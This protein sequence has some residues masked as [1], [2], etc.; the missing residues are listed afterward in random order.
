MIEVVPVPE[1][2]ASGVRLEGMVIPQVTGVLRRSRSGPAPRG[3]ACSHRTGTDRGGVRVAVASTAAKRPGRESTAP[4]RRWSA[5]GSSFRGE[6]SS[7]P[8]ECFAI[9]SARLCSMSHISD[10]KGFF[11][12]PSR[13]V[14]TFSSP[15]PSVTPA[16][17]DRLEIVWRGAARCSVVRWPTRLTDNSTAAATWVA[18]PSTTGWYKEARLR[19]RLAGPACR[20]CCL[21]RCLRP[22]LRSLH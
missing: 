10:P 14:A 9:F 12:H 21:P 4:P 17:F 1:H 5:L 7:S 18:I 19:R 16:T 2:I 3:R 22:P 6:H 20:A 8:R 15:S 13:G 11:S